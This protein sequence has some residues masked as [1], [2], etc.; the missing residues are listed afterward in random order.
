MKTGM[1]D[2]KL[3]LSTHPIYCLL[4]ETLFKKS[5]LTGKKDLKQ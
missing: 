4:M 1:N 3:L 5:L 2:L